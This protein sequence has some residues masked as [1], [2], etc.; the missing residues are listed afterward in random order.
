MKS[1]WLLVLVGLILCSPQC[2]GA[3][4]FKEHDEFVKKIEKV[5]R[6]V[7]EIKVGMTRADVLKVFSTS[8]GIS[9][10]RSRTYVY[11]ECPYIKVDVEFD[12][13]NSKEPA[14]ESAT[15]RITKISRPYLEGGIID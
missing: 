14:H 5:L 12:T 1:K 9:T 15:D 13:G 4:S 2:L 3:E 11:R 6:D 7:G 10:G 8:G